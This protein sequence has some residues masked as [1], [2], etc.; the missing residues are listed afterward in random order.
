V[1]KCIAVIVIFSSVKQGS[2][3]RPN[4]AEPQLT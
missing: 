4:I 2:F 1:F 3:P